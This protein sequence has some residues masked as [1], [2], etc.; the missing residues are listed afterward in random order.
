MNELGIRV[1][2][3]G[4]SVRAVRDDSGLALTSSA[5]GVELACH[6]ALDKSTD[7]WFEL[8]TL[9]TH[10]AYADALRVAAD[11][12]TGEAVATR[13]VRLTV[14]RLKNGCVALEV[15]SGRTL[16]IPLPVGISDLA[17]DVPPEAAG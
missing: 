8:S 12:G 3:A 6:W 5:S 10:S 15:I 4:S 17:L 11:G 16:W 14:T 1:T 2:R 9:F 13:G 7:E